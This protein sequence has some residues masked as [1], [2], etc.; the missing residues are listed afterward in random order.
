M[1]QEMAAGFL[2]VALPCQEAV[3]GFLLVAPYL[4][5][6]AVDRGVECMKPQ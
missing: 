2:A 3:A 5:Q 1:Q 4:F 6:A